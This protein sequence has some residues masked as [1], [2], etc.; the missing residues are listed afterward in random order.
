MIQEQQKNIRKSILENV[1][2]VSIGTP[3]GFSALRSVR[4]MLLDCCPPDNRFEDDELYRKMEGD[5]EAH[6][7]APCTHHGTCPMERHQKFFQKESNASEGERSPGNMEDVIDGNK[8]DDNEDEDIEI[9]D[10]DDYDD[11]DDDEDDLEFEDDENIQ[12]YG[13]GSIESPRETD[14]FDSAFC[15]FVHSLPGG[16][17]LKRG[18][19]ISYLVVQKRICGDNNA[20]YSDTSFVEKENIVDL[21][22]KSIKN[23]KSAEIIETDEALAKKAADSQELLNKAIKI[24]DTYLDSDKDKLNLELV[25]GDINRRSWGRIIRAP[26]KKKGHI[27]VDYCASNRGEDQDTGK[28]FR[29]NVSRGPCKKAA[30]GMY[31]ASRKSRWGGFWPHVGGND[32]TS[33]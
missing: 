14:V 25:Q 33:K 27:I 1:S 22:T 11:Y 5:E 13:G 26:I 18:E 17:R 16:N 3:D 24:Q 4:S 28:I 20:N 10:G 6:I 9:D 29:I 12:S 23:H 19:K 15:S 8:D 31:H 7:I 2:L 21:L 30:P 32:P